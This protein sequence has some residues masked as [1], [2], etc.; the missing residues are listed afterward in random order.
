MVRPRPRP[1][2]LAAALLTAALATPAVAQRLP[3]VRIETTAGVIV[4]EI[5]TA[6]APVSGRNFLTYVDKHFY[7]RGVFHRTV[8]L[9]NQPN[10]AVKIEV[11]QASGDT[12]RAGEALP[13]IKLE[14]TSV[15]GLRHRAGT[16][17]MARLGP[18]TAEDQFFICVTDQPELDF[19]GKRN[20]DGQ[21]FAAFGR[22]MSG[23]EVV[24]KIHTS[25]ADGQ[26]LNPL[27]KIVRVSRL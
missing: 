14:R 2:P 27:I 26:R 23:M 4:A 7:D 22:V 15:T 16:L 5:D 6:K 20:P 12:T 1:R 21:G 19:G 13:P 18:D 9:A 11:I 10:N 3:R 8:T 17:S 24:K 25:K